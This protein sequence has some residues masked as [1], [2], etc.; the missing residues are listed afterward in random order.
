MQYSAT[1]QVTYS[2]LKSVLAPAFILVG[3]G[4]EG[5][6]AG[7]VL[8]ILRAGVTGTI[9]LFTK[10]V[11]HERNVAKG[12]S[13]RLS[14]LLE[15][16]LPLYLAAMLSVFL[17]QYQNIV[18]ARSAT[19]LVIGNFNAA[20]NFNMLFNILIYPITNATFPM[21]AK[22]D[23]NQKTELAAVKYTSLVMIPA[24]VAVMVFS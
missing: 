16:G 12:S 18:L 2:M 13:V 21:F 17:T 9:I 14:T 4:L 22:M 8:G 24:S 5:A 19:D 11:H 1:V 3:F 23:S 6:I 15:Y 7:Y 20:W 10:Y